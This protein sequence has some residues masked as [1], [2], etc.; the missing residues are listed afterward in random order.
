MDSISF[1]LIMD[2]LGTS[3]PSTKI[4]GEAPPSVCN[5]PLTPLKRMVGSPPKSPL[6]VETDNP[7]TAPCS[8]LPT[9][10][11]G[12]VSKVFS[13]STVETEP[14]MLDLFCEPYPTTTTS[15]RV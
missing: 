3:T 15:S 13:V 11:M 1:G 6:G 8:A 12:R 9:S 4:N 10:V 7:E 2:K 14:V 5:D